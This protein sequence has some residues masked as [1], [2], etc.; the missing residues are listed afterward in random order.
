MANKFLEFTA[1][2]GKTCALNIKLIEVVV[3]YTGSED[4]S[5]VSKIALKDGGIY[6]SQ[7]P[8]RVLIS[9]LNS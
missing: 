6:F 1:K 2:N 4:A 8:I 5:I 3:E 9:N 7:T